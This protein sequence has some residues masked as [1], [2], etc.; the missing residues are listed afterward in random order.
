MFCPPVP[1]PS[2]CAAVFGA[3]SASRG[4]IVRR[5][6]RDI[7]REFGR[8]AF[9]AE[10]RL[11]GFHLVECGDQFIVICNDGQMKVHC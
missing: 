10:V 5:A 2:W 3:K 4:G 11:R 9:F 8:D 6:V 1:N 7:E